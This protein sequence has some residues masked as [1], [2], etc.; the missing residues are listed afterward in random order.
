MTRSSLESFQMG[1]AGVFEFSRIT[2][3]ARYGKVYV[4]VDKVSDQNMLNYHLA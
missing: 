1:A 2:D 4:M 3:S